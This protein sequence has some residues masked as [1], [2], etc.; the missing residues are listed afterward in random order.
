[1]RAIA[2][3]GGVLDPDGKTPLDMRFTFTDHSAARECL[4]R[5]LDWHPR[6]VVLAH[7]R[8]YAEDG[9]AELRRAFRWLHP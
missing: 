7:G 2:R 4:R 9:K 8:W 1:M 6:R 3:F 5:M